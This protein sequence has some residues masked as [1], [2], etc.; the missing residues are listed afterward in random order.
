[1]YTYLRFQTFLPP[2][3]KK[4]LRPNVG[5]YQVA[6]VHSKAVLSGRRA[7]IT[8]EHRHMIIKIRQVAVVVVENCAMRS[9]SAWSINAVVDVGTS[10]PLHERGSGS[11]VCT[12]VRRVCVHR[13]ESHEGLMEQVEVGVNELRNRATLTKHS[14]SVNVSQLN[15]W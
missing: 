13:V 9:A 15:D 10:E 14:L 3:V 5:P 4:R 8:L 6:D 12:N 1:M 7:I 2:R 11:C